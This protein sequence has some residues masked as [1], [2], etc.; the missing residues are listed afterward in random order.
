MVWKNTKDEKRHSYPLLAMHDLSVLTKALKMLR[1]IQNPSRRPFTNG[2]ISMH[3]QNLNTESLTSPVQIV[4]SMYT[5]FN[6]RNDWIKVLTANLNLNH[7][8]CCHARWVRKYLHSPKKMG[9]RKF[10]FL[11][12][13]IAM[14]KLKR[15]HF[16]FESVPSDIGCARNRDTWIKH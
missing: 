10:H 7:R 13:V 9:M 16:S 11:V 8:A 6:D 2:L 14:P 4:F 15:K 5:I 3:F 12:L 1:T